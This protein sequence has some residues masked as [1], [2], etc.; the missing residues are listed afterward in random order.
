MPMI[1]NTANAIK[2][3]V[4]ILN[5]FQECWCSSFIMTFSTCNVTGVFQSQQVELGC[6]SQQYS[7]LVDFE[8]SNL[9]QHLTDHI[10]P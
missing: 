7:F 6:F 8:S 1:L 3:Y 10:F 4:E 2:G 5:E 9:Y